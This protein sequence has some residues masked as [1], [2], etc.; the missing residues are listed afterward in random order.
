MWPSSIIQITTRPS[1]LQKFWGFMR[2]ELLDYKNFIERNKVQQV[3]SIRLETKAGKP[4]VE[5]LFSEEIFGRM[6]SSA[7]R[8]TFGYIDLVV[9]VVHPEAWDLIVGINP[10]FGKIVTGSARYLI[11]SNGDLIED[12]EGLS[13][14][15]GISFLVDNW[16]K[17]NLNLLGEKHP[18]NVEFC[19]KNA[20]RLFIDK[21]L[22]L[23]AGVRD[24]NLSKATGKTMITASEINNLYQDLI[25]N[26]K[27]VNPDALE[28]MS[29]DIK[30]S[31]TFAIQKNVLEI[32][33]WIKQRLKGKTGLIRGGLLSKTV[34]YS[35]RFAIVGDPNLDFGTI[36]LPWQVVLKLYEPFVYYELLKNQL[37]AHV[38]TMVQEFLGKD[39][40]P[41]QSDIKRF[42]STLTDYPKSVN[43]TLKDELIRIAREIVKNKC[44]LYKRDPVESRNSYM[45]GNVAV[46]EDGF[47]MHI[48]MLDLPRCGGDFDGDTM[49]VKQYRKS[50]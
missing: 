25:N 48:N 11:G 43:Q 9:K 4:D 13:G 2:L 10:A 45:A 19:K 29:D 38:L 14:S 39:R 27:M 26:T 15:T 50:A 40:K 30:Q 37:N 8:S 22:V 32:D 18:K 36:G 41:D 31:I 17:L 7:R 5:G 34:D 16:D 33:N 46:L 24:I 21:F 20:S 44:V 12:T 42:L 47:A 1:F 35:G 3:K 28:Y 6:G 23:P 49:G